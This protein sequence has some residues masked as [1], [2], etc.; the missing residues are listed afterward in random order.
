ME[1][2]PSG[3]LLPDWH[4]SNDDISGTDND[5]QPLSEETVRV[6]YRDIA[7]AILYMHTHN[8]VHRDI[9]PSNILM[10]TSN[11]GYGGAKLADFAKSLTVVF[12]LKIVMLLKNFA[13]V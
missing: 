13:N 9:K 6:I 12:L 1:Y 8:V 7:L 11:V 3:S 10:S 2:L 5:I 4:Q